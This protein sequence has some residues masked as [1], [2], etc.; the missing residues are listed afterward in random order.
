M[1]FRSF[2]FVKF[3]NGRVLMG[4]KRYISNE[5]MTKF[6]LKYSRRKTVAEQRWNINWKWLIILG[7]GYVS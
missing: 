2:N 5:M 7:D 3:D 1:K 6:A 4:K